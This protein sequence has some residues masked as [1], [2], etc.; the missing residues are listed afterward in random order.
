MLVTMRPSQPCPAPH[1]CVSKSPLLATTA[2]LSTLSPNLSL[3]RSEPLNT[4]PSVELTP[5]FSQSC[6]LFCASQKVKSFTICNIRTLSPKHP[7]VGYP[8][9]DFRLSDCDVSLCAAG[10]TSLSLRHCASEA[11]NRFEEF[12]LLAPYFF[13]HLRPQLASASRKNSG[14]EIAV[15][16]HAAACAVACQSKSRECR[17][18]VPFQLIMA[19]NYVYVQQSLKDSQRY[20]GMCGDLRDRIRDHEAG[21]VHSTRFRR[22]LRL[23]YYEACIS[24]SDAARREIYLKTGRGKKYLAQRLRDSI[25]AISLDKLERH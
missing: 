25:A 10:D 18:L 15:A 3:F 12:G 8:K 23:I 11:G 14:P 22:P 2:R 9:P 7:G 21:R 19:M 6:E 17:K 1:S 13:R 20:T 24:R 5:V 4:P 16:F